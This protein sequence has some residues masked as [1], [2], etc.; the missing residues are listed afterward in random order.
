MVEW[1]NPIFYINFGGFLLAA[2]AFVKLRA[3]A[4]EGKADTAWV[5]FLAILAVG[6]FVHF[7]GDLIDY[8]DDIDHIFIHAVLLVAL[9]ALAASLV[10]G[11]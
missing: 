8:P 1:S 11:E 3:L 7:L 10:R 5:P 6:T 4:K 2:F 9:A